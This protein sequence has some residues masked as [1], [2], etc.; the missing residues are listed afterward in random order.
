[1]TS[2]A[3]LIN[4]Q[5]M[6]STRRKLVEQDVDTDEA[7]VDEEV[8]RWPDAAGSGNPSPDSVRR[9]SISFNSK[10]PT[11][12]SS[13]VVVGRAMR[14]DDRFVQTTPKDGA[15]RAGR[16]QIG[17]QRGAMV[18]GG[19]AGEG[20]ERSTTADLSCLFRETDAGAAEQRTEE[21]DVV[22]DGIDGRTTS[23]ISRR[24][25]RRG[26]LSVFTTQRTISTRQHPVEDETDPG[27]TFKT[28]QRATAA[29]A[30]PW[31]RTTA[32]RGGIAIASG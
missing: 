31:S 26:A 9:S 14:T 4:N 30:K 5:K 7:P 8:R 11:L 3:N 24:R 23:V 10:E 21:P 27:V 32:T 28:L 18:S 1:M 6:I 13:V 20:E 2:Q 12:S 17:A 15:R 29:V 25:V 16:R 19:G 22:E